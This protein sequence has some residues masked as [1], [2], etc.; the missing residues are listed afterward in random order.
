MAPSNWKH[1][2]DLCIL[3]RVFK[4]QLGVPLLSFLM[5]IAESGVS[6]DS[7]T[8]VFFV[9]TD[10]EPYWMNTFEQVEMVA[11]LFNTVVFNRTFVHVLPFQ[12]FEHPNLPGKDWGYSFTDKALQEVFYNQSSPASKQCEYLIVTNADNYYTRGFINV[13]D[14][15]GELPKDMI[16][17]DFVSRYTHRPIT[18]RPEIGS[19]DLGAVMWKLS[20]LTK[21]NL[22]YGDKDGKWAAES[23]GWAVENAEKLTTEK[24]FLKKILFIHQLCFSTFY[25]RVAPGQWK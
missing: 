13:I 5:S 6:T 4:N 7:M 24:K 10:S 3:A 18:A 17:F 19:I 9:V 21:H 20:F 12:P 1:K 25:A 14:E 16:F 15:E 8:Q 2:I 22:L 23:D 11:T